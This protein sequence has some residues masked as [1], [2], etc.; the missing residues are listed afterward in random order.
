MP[1]IYKNGVAY[2]GVNNG[3]DL[4]NAVAADGSASNVQ[5]ELNKIANGTTIVRKAASLETIQDNGIRMNDYGNIY[6]K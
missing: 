3:A 4:I 6:F 2:A 5:A 1:A